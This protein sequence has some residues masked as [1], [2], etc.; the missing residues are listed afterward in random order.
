MCLSNHEL[1]AMSSGRRD[2]LASQSNDLLDESIAPRTRRSPHRSEGFFASGRGSISRLS[3]PDQ[4]RILFDHRGP[5]VNSL[6]A[7]L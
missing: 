3:L 6:T 7:G 2:S 4:R 5:S 1:S